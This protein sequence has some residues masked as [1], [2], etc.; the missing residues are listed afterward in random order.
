MKWFLSIFAASLLASHVHAQNTGDVQ[1][2]S[3]FR[4]PS[5]DQNGEMT[6]QMFGDY[7]KIL[8]DGYVEIAQLKMEFY[9]N[10]GTNRITNMRVTSPRCIYN[11]TRGT[12][13]SDSDVRIA[14]D[15][16]VVTGTGFLWN[17]EDQFLKI[18]QNAK[19]VLKN[20][21]TNIQEGASP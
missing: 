17:N 20:A 4:V 8:P 10:E 9:S 18:T 2:V 16:M 5:Y 21:H 7:A 14:R 15:D 12:A 3:G 19:V 6:S 1:T 13:V 11:R